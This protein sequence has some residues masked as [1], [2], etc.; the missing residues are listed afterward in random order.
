MA[1]AAPAA[2]PLLIRLEHGDITAARASVI[3]VN[4]LNG[5]PPAGSE[6]AVDEALGR[7]ISRTAARGGLQTSFGS[8]RFFPAARAA[9]AA[10]A[11]L[12]VGLGEPERFSARRLPEIG[13]AIVEALTAARLPDAATIVHGAGLAGAD[14][15]DAVTALVRGIV[16]ARARVPEA[17]LVRSITLVEYDPE[18]IEAMRDALAAQPWSSGAELWLSADGWTRRGGAP[19]RRAARRAPARDVL[20][21]RAAPELVPVH[22]RIGITRSGT[23]LKVTV[24]GDDALDSSDERPYPAELATTLLGRIQTEVLS[25]DSAEVRRR[26]MLAI[27]DQL[28]KSFLSP[29]RL[30]VAAV[31]SGDEERPLVLRLD[32]STVQMPWELLRIGDRFTSRTRSMAR[33][34]EGGVPGRTAP[35]ID[36]DARSLDALVVGDPSGNLPAARGEAESVA[37]AL[38]RMPGVRVRALVRNVSYTDLSLALDEKPYDLVHYAGHAVHD[39]LRGTALVLAGDGLMTADDLATRRYLPR[40]FVGN[41]CYA[42]T[43]GGETELLVDTLPLLVTGLLSAGVRAFVGAQWPVG[44]RAARTFASSFYRALLRGST[45]GEATRAAREAVVDAHGEGE[46]AWASYALYG[47]PWLTLT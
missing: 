23:D 34:L 7:A 37:Q 33:Q 20:A 2:S 9:L 47:P 14:A 15:G 10:E 5:L 44:D 35:A 18:R 28:R 16:A 17:D 19:P 21:A 6:K 46:P 30:D 24:I 43:T 13:A 8:T 1:G 36:D 27:G 39:A 41:A 38:R 31:I 45:I 32:R 29:P 25:R 42:G 3:V 40:I 4:H 26:A 11:V 12:V 22:T